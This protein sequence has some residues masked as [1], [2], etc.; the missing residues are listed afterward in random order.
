MNSRV[1]RGHLEIR[2]GLAV[3]AQAD[4]AFQLRVGSSKFPL[5]KQRKP[6]SFVGKN[7]TNR[8][9]YILGG[10]QQ[11]FGK[12][13]SFTKRCAQE[14]PGP[15]TKHCGKGVFVKTTL[16]AQLKCARICILPTIRAPALGRQEGVAERRLKQLSNLLRSIGS[17]IL[18]ISFSPRFR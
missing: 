11:M 4:A 14:I 17:A 3:L 5:C 13:L 12:G 10:I 15:Q 1:L 16:S 9:V 7:L 6:Q 8:V 18:G 2:R